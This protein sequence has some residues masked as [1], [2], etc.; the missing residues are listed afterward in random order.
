[1]N[2]KIENIMND[3]KQKHKIEEISNKTAMEA[4][5][6]IKK[7]MMEFC[8]K[9]MGRVII[10]ISIILLLSGRCW[11]YS[12]TGLVL[13]LSMD[14]STVNGSTIYDQSGQ[15]N[16]GTITGAVTATG[17]LKQCR[18]FDGS[19]DYINMGDVLDQGTSSFSISMW[20]RV[21]KVE[22][23]GIMTKTDWFFSMGL[24]GGGANKIGFGLTEDDGSNSSKIFTNLSP[25]NGV[26]YH[27]VIA[28]DKDTF[29]NSKIYSDGVDITDS[30]IDGSTGNIDN[31]HNLHIGEY[32]NNYFDGLIDEV[33]IYNRALTAT[34]VKD[35]YEGSKY[36]NL[37]VQNDTGLVL[38]LSMDDSTVNGSTIYDKS[39]LGNDGT[40]TGAGTATGKLKQARSFNGTSN[41]ITVPD[42]SDYSFVLNNQAF[43]LACWFYGIPNNTCIIAEHY[44]AATDWWQLSLRQKTD[45][46]IS[47]LQ[48]RMRRNNSGDVVRHETEGASIV[49]NQWNYCVW[50]YDG[51]T[52]FTGHVNGSS[53]GG[54]SEAQAST[55]T[56]NGPNNDL[57]IGKED[58]EGGRWMTGRLDEYKIYNRALTA[59]EVKDLYEASKKRAFMN[60][61]NDA[62]IQ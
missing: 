16:D 57:Y 7:E 58:N 11:A 60:T 35:L 2:D 37:Q 8:C 42:T 43:T 48:A 17:K 32:V 59:T 33:K 30:R 36:C 38:S 61:G 31:G 26:W 54:F 9:N 51:V 3:L 45:S 14:D 46:S 20:A 1:M 6:A 21:D 4:M 56:P 55:A 15:G 5:N 13:D 24:H 41:Y 22:N 47:E 44:D 40:I 53:V 34:E 52:T 50:V 39:G 10:A 49:A 27:F 23:Q 19:D 12:K 28:V 29:N 18:E 25:L 62:N